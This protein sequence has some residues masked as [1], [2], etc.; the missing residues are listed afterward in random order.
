[1]KKKKEEEEEKSEEESDEEK[2]ETAKKKIRVSQNSVFHL[3]S[4][5]H[6]LRLTKS[7]PQ[8]EVLCSFTENNMPLTL[9]I[10]H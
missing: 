4:N 10:C 6:Q 3:S 2:A 1:M 8:K 7:H 9:A 5:K